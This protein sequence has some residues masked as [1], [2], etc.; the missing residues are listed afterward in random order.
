MDVWEST[1]LAMKAMHTKI[2]GV[3]QLSGQAHQV[4]PKSRK[5]VRIPV[6]IVG[7]LKQDTYSLL[8]HLVKAIQNV[9]L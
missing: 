9:I 7:S 3:S 4:F 8:Y 1:V 2:K 6:M 5:W